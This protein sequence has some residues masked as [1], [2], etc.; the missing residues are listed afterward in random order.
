MK[1]FN[2]TTLLLIFSLFITCNKDK[3][4]A[5]LEPKIYFEKE[6]VKIEVKQDTDSYKYDIITRISDL[7]EDDVNVEYQIGSSAIVEEYNQKNGTKYQYMPTENLSLE[8][9][10]S[11]IKKGD[12]YAQPCKLTVT[13]LNQ[14]KEGTSFLIPIQIKKASIPT[15]EAKTIFISV[16]KPIV[17]SKVAR[18]HGKYFSV[19]I[20]A[21]TQFKSVTYEALIYANSFNWIKTIMGIEG[22]LMFRFGDTTIETNQIQIAGGIQFNASILFD[23]KKWYHVAFVYNGSTK[24]A[25]IYINGEKVANK[26]VDISSFD[27]NSGNFF[28]G[29]AYDYDSSRTWNGYMSECRIWNIARTA[30]QLRENMLGVDPQT[31]GLFAYWKLNGTDSYQKNGK[32]YIKDQTKQGVDIISRTGNYNDGAGTST[33]PEIVDLKVNIN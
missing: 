31:E 3:E 11:T 4:N 6:Q 21:N 9:S 14:I 16:V 13:K 26:T 2:Y 22:N 18:F 33:E 25:E 7:I 27:L 12:I 23:T 28:I 5:L 32:Y 8:T 19:P 30:N 10:S 29:Y 17:I 20:P 24:L 15:I 1:Y